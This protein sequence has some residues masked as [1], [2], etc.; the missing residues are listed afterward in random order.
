MK[1]Y[2]NTFEKEGMQSVITYFNSGNVIFIKEGLSTIKITN[3]L[4]NAINKEF[5]LKIKMVACNLE[6]I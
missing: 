5:Y 2:K 6:G 3:N 1:A 4:E